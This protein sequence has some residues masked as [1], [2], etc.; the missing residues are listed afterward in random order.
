[1][2]FFDGLKRIKNY[3][4]GGSAE[5]DIEFLQE[6]RLHE[7]F[8]IKV[9]LTIGDQDIDSNEIY[10]EVK[11]TEHVE[12]QARTYNSSGQSTSRTFHNAANLYEDRISFAEDIILSAN[13]IYEFEA[14]LH[15][16]PEV[17][18]SFQGINSK[19][20]WTL[21]AFIDTRGNDPN[22]ELVEFEPLV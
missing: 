18:P 16:P 22:S 5:V 19:L 17:V 10:L 2:G 21:Q 15:F 4:T 9:V 6:C 3:F 7:P 12:V 8:N 11:N 14:Q 1:M 13:E 20:V